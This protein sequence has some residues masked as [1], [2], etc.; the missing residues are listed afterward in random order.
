MR[1][2]SISAVILTGLTLTACEKYSN[3]GLSE[4]HGNAVYQNEAVH[5]LPPKYADMKEPTM[6]GN[7]GSL[8]FERYKTGTTIKPSS[9]SI[10]GLGGGSG[11]GGGGD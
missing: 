4:D 5:I 7:R 6:D 8:A 10:S 3:K 1:I 11:A 2:V 9:S